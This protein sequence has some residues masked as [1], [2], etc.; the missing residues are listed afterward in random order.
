MVAPSIGRTITPLWAHDAPRRESPN[1]EVASGRGRRSPTRPAQPIGPAPRG[2]DA[3]SEDER[4]LAELGYKQ[5]LSRAWSGFT[6]FAI[7]FTIISVLAGTFTT[8]FQ[9]WNS[10]GPIAISIGWPVLCV[11]VLMVAFSMSELTSAYPD[12]GRALLVVGEAGRPRLELVHR[13]VQHRRPDRHRRLGGIRGGVLPGLP[14]R[15]LRA[16]HP[17]R[18]LRRRRARAHRD[19]PAVPDHPR[20]RHRSSTSSATGSW[21]CSTTSRS[22]GT[23]SGSR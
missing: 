20:I 13:L 14:V 1:R 19:I 3:R 4:R 16:Q 9:A 2:E 23:C 15:P 7:S 17:R 11:F 5:E 18:Q 22:A 8:F 12:G 6:N 10:G 21:R